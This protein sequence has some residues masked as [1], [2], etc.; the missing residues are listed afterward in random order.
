MHTNRIVT[1]CTSR[2]IGVGEHSVGQLNMISVNG[3]TFEPVWESILGGLP[4][5]CSALGIEHPPAGRPQL[6]ILGLTQYP[7]FKFIRSTTIENPIPVLTWMMLFSGGYI[8]AFLPERYGGLAKLIMPE[9]TDEERKHGRRVIPTGKIRH[10]RG[11][12]AMYDWEFYPQFLPY[13]KTT[14]SKDPAVAI[15]S[16]QDPLRFV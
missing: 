11:A 12:P 9:F 8:Q 10:I 5:K 2:I 4:I 15:E 7:W 13:I 14:D 1:I 3:S 6:V 16:W